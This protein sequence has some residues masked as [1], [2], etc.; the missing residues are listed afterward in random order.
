MRIHPTSHLSSSR[1]SSRNLKAGRTSLGIIRN[2]LKISIDVI[3][4]CRRI[5][6]RFRVTEIYFADHARAVRTDLISRA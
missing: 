1:Y 6:G 2:L 3:V 4:Q 5:D